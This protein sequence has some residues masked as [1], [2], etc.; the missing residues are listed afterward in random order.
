MLPLLNMRCAALAGLLALTLVGCGRPDPIDRDA[1][2]ATFEWLIVRM[3]DRHLEPESFD[4][5]F[6]VVDVAVID[7][8]Q[9]DYTI[10]AAIH[11]TRSTT[12]SNCPQ[13]DPAVREIDRADIV[14]RF[15]FCPV[16]RT[17][18][19]A[20]GRIAG[21]TRLALPETWRFVKELRPDG[22]AQSLGLEW[23]GSI[24]GLTVRTRKTGTI[25]SREVVIN[26]DDHAGGSADSES[27]GRQ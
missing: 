20:D 9:V 25:Y 4:V 22:H 21:P 17:A 13:P 27:G 6:K 19:D 23:R 8:W 7:R 3:L 11:I 1:D 24:E 10:D 15:L 26:V 18:A 12:L 2:I 14:P 5:P 16:L